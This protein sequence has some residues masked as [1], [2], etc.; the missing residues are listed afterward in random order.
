VKILKKYK[1]E[2]EM[3]TLTSNPSV[4]EL[5]NYMDWTRKAAQEAEETGHYQKAG[6]LMKRHTWASGEIDMMK[7]RF[8]RLSKRG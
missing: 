4:E 2:G 8:T 7:G 3:M 6:Y 1:N 5:E